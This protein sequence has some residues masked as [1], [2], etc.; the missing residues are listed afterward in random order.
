[1]ELTVLEHYRRSQRREVTRILSVGA[2]FVSI[3][4]LIVGYGLHLRHGHQAG[5]EGVIA[6][7]VAFVGVG[8][9]S[10]I[11]RMQRLLSDEQFLAVLRS[12]LLYQ[13][14]DSATEIAW[15]DVL[16]IRC[17]RERDQVVIDRKTGDSVV[18]A[19]GFDGTTASALARHLEHL[20]IK[21]GM[22]LL[23]R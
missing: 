13:V 5:A 20:R 19:F 10:T 2:L 22:N 9:I 8:P 21:A 17:D 18:V 16:A 12:G 15:D 23:G 4:A 1:V 11:I 14:N 3:G 7:G 6:F